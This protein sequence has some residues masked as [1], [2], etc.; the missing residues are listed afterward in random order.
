M[1]GSRFLLLFGMIGVILTAFVY[2]PA[3]SLAGSLPSSDIKALSEFISG[4]PSDA[5][6]PKPE[7]KRKIFIN[8]LSRLDRLIEKGRVKGAIN[9]TDQ[10]LRKVD[11]FLGGKGKND[12]VV[13][14]THQLEIFSSLSRIRDRIGELAGSG[15]P[16]NIPFPSVE[17]FTIA[18]AT[19]VLD[20]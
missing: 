12:W 3:G 13:D 14:P 11:A 10:L 17:P 16:A 5:F 1:A 7:K 9:R 19:M 4:L 15:M 8:N 20:T 18:A 6:A 2:S